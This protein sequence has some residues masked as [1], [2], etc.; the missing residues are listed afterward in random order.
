MEEVQNKRIKSKNPNPQKVSQK[1]MDNLLT[2]SG[3]A[4]PAFLQSMASDRR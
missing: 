3:I 4:G 1:I 2:N